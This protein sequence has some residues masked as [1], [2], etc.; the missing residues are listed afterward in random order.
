MFLKRKSSL[1][2]ECAR[3]LYPKNLKLRNLN[4]IF[5]FVTPPWEKHQSEV[6]LYWI[7]F[8]NLFTNKFFGKNVSND[9][10]YANCTGVDLQPYF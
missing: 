7:S 4:F 5:R 9:F 3:E 2:Y 8:F 1:S 10:T 6:A